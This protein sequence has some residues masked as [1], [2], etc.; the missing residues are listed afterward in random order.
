[1]LKSW[2]TPPTLFRDFNTFQFAG[3]MG[4]VIFVVLLLFMTN[5]SGYHYGSSVNLPKVFHPVSMPSAN[6]EDAMIVNVT[7]DGKVYFGVEQVRPAE[8][9][10]KIAD[11]LKDRS[12]ERKIYIKADM[13]ARWGTV[14]PVLDGVRAA[15]ILRVAFLAYQRQSASFHT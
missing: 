12:V 9:P 11:R 15:G 4:V 2:R 6:R 14:K 1:M 3:V 10:Q 8:L 13:R 5:S 7:R